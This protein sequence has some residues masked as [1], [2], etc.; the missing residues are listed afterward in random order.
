MQDRN[1]KYTIELSYEEALI[2]WRLRGLRYGK[3]TIKK[4]D[5]EFIQSITEKSEKFGEERRFDS[6]VNQQIDHKPKS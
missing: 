1:K 4:Q 5:G 6:W 3:V 2:I